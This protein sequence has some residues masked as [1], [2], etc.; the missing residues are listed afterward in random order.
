[1]GILN[2]T[3]DSFSDGGNYCSISEAL[4][5]AKEMIDEG[6]DIIDI[7][8][9]STKPSSNPISEE[10][11]LNRVVPIVEAI[12]KNYD[13]PISIDTY[14]HRVAEEAIKNGAKIINDITGFTYDVKMIEIAKKYR[15]K[16]IIMH[17]SH[18]SKGMNENSIKYIDIIKEVYYFFDKQI[19]ILKN[20]GINDIVIDPG[21][22]FGKT[23][24]D[25][26]KLLANLSL[27]K[28]LNVPILVGVSR[29]SMIGKLKEPNYQTND[30]LAGTIALNTVSILNG[31]SILRVHDIKEHK[32][33]ILALEKYMKSSS[34]N[35]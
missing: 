26:Y 29:K 4:K 12:S 3:P 23:L 31:A 32:Q 19:K 22:G 6:A 28:N 15:A 25:N 2:I 16:S 17:S 30:R 7:G 21:F 24:N 8:G 10:E 14:K 1:M 33:M 18:S 11:E 20:S 5:R 9:E 34:N 35:S 13:I 27:F